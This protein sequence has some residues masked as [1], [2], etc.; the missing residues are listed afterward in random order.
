MNR[1]KRLFLLVLAVGFLVALAAQAAYAGPVIRLPNKKGWLQINYEAQL[2]LQSRDTGS[3]PGGTDD[4]TDIYFRRN[5]LIFHGKANNTYGFY[6][7]LE[8]QGNRRINDLEVQDEVINR[9]SVLDAFIKADYR[10]TFKLRAG[11]IK[12]PLVREHNE[13]C[14]FPLSVD[15][16]P[17]VYTS[18][19]RVSRDYGV[20][21][22][23]NLVGNRLQYKLSLMKGLD[24]ADSPESSLRYTAR[25][26]YSLMDPESLPLYFGTYLGKKKVLTLGAGYQMEADAVYGNV[27]AASLAGDYTAMTYDVFFEYP[28]PMGTVTASG[29]YL[30]TD[31]DEAYKGADPDPASVGINGEKNGWYAK[32]GYLL[33]NKIGPGSLQV[34]GRYEQW[35]FALLKDVLNQEI[36]WVGGG[37]NY[38]LD[39]HKL[40]LTL[41]YSQNDYD[42]ETPDVEDFKTITAMLQLLF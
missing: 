39:G 6:Y 36:T 41:E 1:G 11:L 25:V 22:W 5:R 4:T 21:F 15:R 29:A 2:Y 20:L 24:S 31:F 33:P 23:G 3:G 16:S 42:Q 32:A 26:H 19:P 30:E 12:D 13:G 17:F 35:N 18:I 40:R 38:F 27:A 28:T 9:L 34:Y 7:A 37:V 10:P 14:F 8:H